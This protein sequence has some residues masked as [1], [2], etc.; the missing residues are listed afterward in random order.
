MASKGT[1]DPASLAEYE[2]VSN[3]LGADGGV[4]VAKM[5]SQ[6][7]LRVGSKFFA[8]LFQSELVVK[9]SPDEVQAIV[10]KKQG[11]QFDPMKG[12]PMKEWVQ[13]PLGKVDWVALARRSMEYVWANQGAK[14]S[15]RKS[16]AAK[17][18]RRSKP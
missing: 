12:R 8:M 1:N 14:V 17:P 7:C 5:F 16:P 6:D 15:P 2:K 18:R 9:L 13:V 10:A 11:R 4:E 3:I